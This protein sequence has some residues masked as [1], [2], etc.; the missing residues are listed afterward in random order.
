MK[1][2]LKICK[3]LTLVCFLI[4]LSLEVVFRIVRK[5]QWVK[6]EYPKIYAMDTICGYKGIPNIEGYIRRPSISKKFRLNNHGFYGL[7]F[8]AQKP[9]DTYRIIIVGAS[10]VEGVWANHKEAFPL[11]LQKLFSK[12]GVK[13][14]VLNCAVSGN[15]RDLQN[16]RLIE[17]YLLQ[18]NPDLV[19]YEGRTHISTGNH[20]R[21]TYKDYSILFAGDNTGEKTHSRFIAERE[22]DRIKQLKLFTDLWDLSY[23]VR[24][25]V[26][27]SD[28]DKIPSFA[29]CLQIYL[30]NKAESW[31]YSH[32]KTYSFT[33]SI[34]MLNQL[35]QVLKDHSCK[36]ILF[37]YNTEPKKQIVEQREKIKFSSIFLNVSGENLSHKYDEHPNEHAHQIIAKEMFIKLKYIIPKKNDQGT[38]NPK[39]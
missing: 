25:Y 22:V 39:N 38:H 36:L 21:D 5:E 12:D 9:D 4:V 31:N 30:S 23:I 18:Y 17:Y 13:V 16:I 27:E 11:K 28:T 24:F 26:R 1:N 3:Y 6:H 35:N 10:G 2:I 7:D 34:P 19:L 14:E 32:F 15:D 20:H 33:E 29:N 8:S 37:F